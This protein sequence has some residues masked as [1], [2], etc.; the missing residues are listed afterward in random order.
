MRFFFNET[1]QESVMFGE[2]QLKGL[3]VR[4]DRSLKE[5]QEIREDDIA[6]AYAGAV[7]AND[8]VFVIHLLRF[9][10]SLLKISAF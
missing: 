5:Q 9:E 4:N 3:V 1:Q 10:C 2:I 6:K 7:V 8:D